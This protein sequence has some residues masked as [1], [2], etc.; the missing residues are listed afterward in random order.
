MA[1]SYKKL[2]KLLIDKDMKKKD[3]EQATQLYTLS[4][5]NIH[6]TANIENGYLN[7]RYGGIPFLSNLKDLN[8]KS[9]D[10]EEERL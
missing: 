6:R 2:W 1:I 4:D 7:G 3:L 8:W 9:D 5:Y 10:N